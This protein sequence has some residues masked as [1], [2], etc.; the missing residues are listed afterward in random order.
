MTITTA[1]AVVD[2]LENA[3]S[4]VQSTG[5]RPSSANAATAHTLTRA[6]TRTT[7]RT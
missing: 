6:Q 3:D 2:A 5:A 1:V 4:L 7:P